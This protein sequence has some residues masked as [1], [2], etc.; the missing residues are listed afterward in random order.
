[1]SGLDAETRRLARRLHVVQRDLAALR[2]HPVK[3]EV[4]KVV[5][6]CE[7]GASKAREAS[8][9]IKPGAQAPGSDYQESV[10]AR[11]SG[12]QPWRTTLCRP[13][14]GLRAL[15]FVL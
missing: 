11:D 15:F 5:L 8:D 12:R 4:H 10:R 2:K 3:S 6:A 1:M 14:H 13:F 9:S 7:A